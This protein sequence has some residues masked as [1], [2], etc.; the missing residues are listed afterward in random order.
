[1]SGLWRRADPGFVGCVIFR[2][3]GAE[4]RATFGMFVAIPGSLVMVS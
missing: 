1:M 3:K 4:R 2:M